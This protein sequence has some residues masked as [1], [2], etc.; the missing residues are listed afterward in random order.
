M[1]CVGILRCPTY[2]INKSI[3]PS[4]AGAQDKADARNHSLQDPSAYVVSWAVNGTFGNLRVESS[5]SPQTAA[6]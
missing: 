5:Q 3:L 1:A 2:H 4:G 6:V